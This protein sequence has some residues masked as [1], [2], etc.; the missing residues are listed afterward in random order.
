MRFATDVSS[1]FSNFYLDGEAAFMDGVSLDGNPYM[2]GDDAA[3]AWQAG[4]LA[5]S[6]AATAVLATDRAARLH[7]PAEPL[8]SCVY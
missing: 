5:A 7:R 6:Y 8:A 2:V 4:W 3:A 1:L